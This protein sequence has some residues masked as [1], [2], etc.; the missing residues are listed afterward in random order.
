MKKML[1]VLAIMALVFATTAQAG[2]FLVCDPQAGVTFYKLTGPAWMPTT[3]L[4][5]ADGSI[6]ADV[7]AA[8]LGANNITL[9]ACKTDPVWGERCSAFVPFTFTVP[10][11]PATPSGVKL[12]P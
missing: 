8:V 4:A 7:G 5:N 6:H 10:G 2:P 3:S 9:A 11:V 1:F 12:A